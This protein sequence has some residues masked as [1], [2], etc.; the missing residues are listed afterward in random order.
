VAKDYMAI[1]RRRIKSS[2]QSTRM[3]RVLVYA[4][5]KKGKTRLSTSAPD[6]LMLDPEDGTKHEKKANPDTWPIDTWE[7]LHDV[8]GFLKSRS[9]KSPI[10][11]RPYQWVSWDGCTRICQIALNYIRS[12]EAEKDLMRKPG[13]VDRRDYGRANKLIEEAVHQF[14]ALRDIG[15]IFTAQE[16]MVEIT[17]MEDFGDDEDATPVAYAYVPDMPKGARSVFNGVVDVIGRLYIVRGDF[18]ITKRFRRGDRVIEKEV[19]TTVQRRLWIGPHDM[20]DTGYRSGYELPDFIKNPTIP[21]LVTAM[22]QG[23]VD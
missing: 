20:Y 13:A 12:Q 2:N 19:P 9:N 10:T 15:V 21:S 4:R 7:D 18:T 6:V 16:R 22:Q 14:H 11:G 5:N 17:S 8:A 23:K 3:P 1:A